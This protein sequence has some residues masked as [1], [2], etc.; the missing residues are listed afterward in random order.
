M[1]SGIIENM[2]NK[3]YAKLRHLTLKQRASIAIFILVIL[4]IGVALLSSL[5]KPER[6][7]AA[8][9]KVHQEQTIAL[10]H[11]GGG[12]YTYSSALFPEASSNNPADFIPTFKKLDAVAPVEIEPQVK[13]MGDIFA[14]MS[15]EPTQILSLAMNGLPAERAVT[16]WTQQHCKK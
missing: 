11:A 2:S 4:I 5:T 7:I 8:Y 13:A 10:G 1:N 3:A 9:C 6:S 14:K 16:E 12:K 15:E